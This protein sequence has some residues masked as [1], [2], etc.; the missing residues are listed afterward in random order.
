MPTSSST[1]SGGVNESKPKDLLE[2]STAGTGAA[3]GTGTGTG[4]GTGASGAA[5][6]GLKRPSMTVK[7]YSDAN[8]SAY[9]EWNVIKKNRFGRR[10][11]RVFGVDGEKVYNSKRADRFDRAAVQRAQRDLSAIMKIEYVDGDPKSFRITWDDDNAVYDIEY[12]CES[13]QDCRQIVA[14]LEYLT[15][16]SRRRP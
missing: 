6:G 11:E 9:E 3:G 8:A 16:N 7:S 14:K 15:S 12:T 10:Q 5:T 2:S 13:V 1:G 4:T